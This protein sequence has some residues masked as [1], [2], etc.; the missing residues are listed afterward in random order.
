MEELLTYLVTTVVGILLIFLFML[1][2]R[3]LTTI[4]KDFYIREIG[5]QRS[6]EEFLE[7]INF[8][9]ENLDIISQYDAEMLRLTK[10]IGKFLDALGRFGNFEKVFLT[11]IFLKPQGVPLQ[12]NPFL[13]AV[14][15]RRKF[16]LAKSYLFQFE[17]L[18]SSKKNSYISGADIEDRLQLFENIIQG[19]EYP[20]LV[21]KYE[22]AT[23]TL[24]FWFRSLSFFFLWPFWYSSFLMLLPAV[25]LVG[26]S[27]S[28][29]R[30]GRDSV[31]FVEAFMMASNIT[32]FVEEED[33]GGDGDGSNDLL[34][35]IFFWLFTYYVSLL[36]M[37]QWLPRLRLMHRILERWIPVGNELVLHKHIG[38]LALLFLVLAAA[39][40]AIQSQ[41]KEQEGGDAEASVRDST[42]PLAFQ[43]AFVPLLLLVS[44]GGNGLSVLLR[45]IQ[46]EGVLEWFRGVYLSH[47]IASGFI[48]HGIYSN[49][50]IAGAVVLLSWGAGSLLPKLL[51]L[52]TCQSGKV[53]VK[54]RVEYNHRSVCYLYLNKPY[55]SEYQGRLL[56]WR[57]IYCF[58]LFPIQAEIIETETENYPY[59]ITV[60]DPYREDESFEE[61]LNFKLT[62]KQSNLV[63][64]SC[65]LFKLIEC[66]SGC[67]AAV[68]F[69]CLQLR[70]E[71]GWNGDGEKVFVFQE[72]YTFG[73]QFQQELHKFSHLIWMVDDAGVDTAAIS[74]LQYLK[75][76]EGR[77]RSDYL[78]VWINCKFTSLASVIKLWNAIIFF[79]VE[80]YDVS[81]RKLRTV[82]ETNIVEQSWRN[83]HLQVVLKV[84]STEDTDTLV[85]KLMNSLTE[86]SR[87]GYLE[88][89]IEFLTLRRLLLESLVLAETMKG[90]P[91]QALP[92]L[93]SAPEETKKVLMITSGSEATVLLSRALQSR[94]RKQGHPVE[95]CEFVSDSVRKRPLKR[96][97][98]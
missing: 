43:V 49:H 1:I 65:C 23:I 84:S 22:G 13:T 77:R 51:Q 42:Q 48:V 60:L 40:Q 45:F 5:I 92:A 7:E 78:N 52:S 53:F 47:L 80:Q 75:P 19:I 63:I 18:D 4:F 83:I 57:P 58:S 21:K 37:L 85:Q 24:P 26:I 36:P 70:L 11:S 3:P 59:L 73:I 96:F 38:L 66:I 10:R 67:F 76:S 81:S 93:K 6:L 72:K 86:A 44:Y 55:A 35:H 82:E 17:S 95:A 30:Q 71:E 74:I 79:Y 50:A 15:V 8:I 98:Y 56:L 12:A 31:F 87:G 91:Y 41:M 90:F 2:E 88:V 62:E 46:L 69:H 68:C 28:L 97:T 25:S 29:R 54:D 39:S 32:R 61:G 33:T 14:V 64:I 27:T 94:L 89:F 9:E 34:T 20:E 16:N